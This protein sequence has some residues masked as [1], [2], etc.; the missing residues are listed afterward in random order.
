[1]VG[2]IVDEDYYEI[3]SAK[4]LNCFFSTVAYR[5]EN[6]I[7]GSVYPTIMNDVYSGVLGWRKAGDAL[8]EL[9]IIAEKLKSFLPADVVWDIDDLTKRPPWG[10]NI[11]EDITD[12]SNYF[13][14]SGGEDLIEVFRNALKNSAENKYDLEIE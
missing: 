10:D 2:F 12:L 13:V 6:G 8:R 14:T 7:R 5:L 4:F 3:G 1:M 9:G 11:S